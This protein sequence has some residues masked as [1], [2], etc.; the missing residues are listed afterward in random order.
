MNIAP[1]PEEKKQILG[2]ALA[3]LHRMGVVTPKVAVLCANEQVSAKMPATER[4]KT[5][6]TRWRSRSPSNRTKRTFAGWRTMFAPA[7]AS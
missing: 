1:G 4:T 7:P 3:A 2:N 6:S 5:R